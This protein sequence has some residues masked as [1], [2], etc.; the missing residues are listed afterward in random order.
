MKTIKFSIFAVLV[1]T[2]VIFSSAWAIPSN[3]SPYVTDLQNEY[4]QDAT[5]EAIG[6]VN[7][8]LCI[9]NAM[10][11]NDSGMLNV[12]P[13]V[14]LIDMKKCES[15]GSDESYGGSSGASVA[16]NY[17][18]AVVDATRASNTA[19][20]IA[21]IWITMAEMGSIMNVFVRMSAGQSPAEVPPYGVFRVDFI[22]KDALGVVR[23]NGFV[24]SASGV[25]QYYETGFNSSN[26]A[27]TMTA[28]ST[29]SG[30]GTMTIGATS[31]T[32]F[33]FNYNPSY[34][35]RSDGTNDQC[36]D[37]SKA[38]ADRSV[39]RFGT[40]NAND[41]SRVDQANPSFPITAS[42]AGSSYYGHAGYYGLSF[43][44][45]NLNGIAD[46]SPISGLVV[47]D[48]RPDNSAT[49]NLS[50]VGGKLT[51]WA[52][53]STTLAAMDGI[54]F[55][56]YGNLSGLVTGN[57]AVTGFG[58]WQMHWNNTAENFTVTGKQNCSS[59]GCVLTS[60]IPAATVNPSAFNGV[61]VSGWSDSFG[62][63]IDIPFTGAAHG[64]SDSMNYFSQ[65]VVIPGSESAPTAL[66]CL[67]NCPDA[68]SVTAANTYT[69]GSVP[70]PFGG[71]TAMQWFSAPNSDSTISYSFDGSGLKNGGAAMIINNADFFDANPMYRHGLTSGRLFD[72]PFSA[73][74]NGVCEP[75]SPSVY[76]TWST[77]IGQWN[78][79][80]WLTK[81]SDS[82]VVAF[83]P[84]QNIVY[85]VPSGE[86]YGTWAG[87][88]IQL[89]FNG[90]GNL[91]GIPGYCVNP[92]DNSQADC[93]T[94]NTRYVPMFS[95][96]DGATMM[97]NGVPLIVKALDAELRLK[98]LGASAAQC[99]SM[100]LSPLSPPTGGVHD[101][102]DSSDIYY[103]GVKP[104][105]T[106]SPKVIDGII[107]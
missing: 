7:M 14:A 70:I 13:Y 46:A 90:F 80:M 49:Y 86:R 89:Q 4:V 71:T 102:S 101:M 16:G 104:V 24:D 21:N 23:F 25:L 1:C 85:T 57:D 59:G 41:G 11:V 18:T 100:S 40:Y 87:K 99:S 66:Y 65:S 2:L 6:S 93:S 20:M 106:T 43:Q 48:Q 55:T 95:I 74:S 98:D 35:R 96:P 38:N 37:R 97:L 36:F 63:N 28:G 78:Q 31:P 39:W 47:S 50:K 81:I 62:G 75:S 72:A 84:P 56:F 22:G 5:S 76:Y 73:C 105:V 64:G 32:T 103:I 15:K 8:V 33:N 92:V 88:T 42:Y 82:S 26:V 53:S 29:T 10:N 30:S 94:A 61:S 12:G 9:I 27:M 19:P 107:Q 68:V 17:M 52:K 67:N 51:K 77:G 91:Y 83:D 69:S 58:N 79:S 45:L 54:P 34:F 44:G 3:E 60:L